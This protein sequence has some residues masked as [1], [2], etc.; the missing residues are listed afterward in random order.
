MPTARLVVFAA[1]D[2]PLPAPRQV[3]ALHSAD[4][5]PLLD[6]DDDAPEILDNNFTRETVTR[7]TIYAGSVRRD[8]A[9]WVAT[10]RAAN[11]LATMLAGMIG[12]LLGTMILRRATR[13]SGTASRR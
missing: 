6:D 3:G 8:P 2:D 1:K 11:A 7:G 13:G 4:L 12:A 9:R 10:Y 5:S